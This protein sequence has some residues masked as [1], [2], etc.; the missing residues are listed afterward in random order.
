VPSEATAVAYDFV[1]M[2]RKVILGNLLLLLLSGIIS[3]QLIRRWRVYRDEHQ[4]SRI[5]ATS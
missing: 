5:G 3:E 2:K 1:G 4:L